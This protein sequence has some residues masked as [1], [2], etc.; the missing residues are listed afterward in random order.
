[1]I[2]SKSSGYRLAMKGLTLD[3]TLFI[4]RLVVLF[5]GR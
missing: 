5:S 3:G 4:D 2:K 1:M